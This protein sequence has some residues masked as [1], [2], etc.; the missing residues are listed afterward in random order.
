LRAAAIVNARRADVHFVWFG[1]GECR[2]AL[3][4]ER[5]RLGLT[6]H[7]HLLGFR[8]NA[9]A[10]IPQF[11]LF[12]LASYLEGLCT[13]LLDAQAL[14]V[15]IVATAVGGIPEV[16]SDG[17]TGRLVPPRDPDALAAAMLD[18]L[19]DPPRRNS[20]A[21]RALETVQAF[22]AARMVEGT[23][24]VYEQVLAEHTAD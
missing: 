10:W 14:G 4:R 11:N 9:R 7:V 2:A 21:A 23:L 13:S 20:W 8:E 22:D 5:T 16:V 1:E 15:P 19:A 12:A 6:D 3:E 24:G 18:A 17:H